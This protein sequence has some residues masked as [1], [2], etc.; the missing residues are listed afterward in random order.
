MDQVQIISEILFMASQFR[1]KNMSKVFISNDRH[2]AS[3]QGS[4]LIFTYVMQ[5]FPLYKT[6]EKC[7]E[8]SARSCPY[9]IHIT[10]IL[11]DFLCFFSKNQWFLT[12]STVKTQSHEE[13]NVCF[14]II[15]KN[16]IELYTFQKKFHQ[17]LTCNPPQLSF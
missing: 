8:K 5:L 12:I 1:T 14:A 17:K 9:R 7:L 16:C 15:T 2:P 6:V 13:I 11:I 10:L 4:R 3:Y